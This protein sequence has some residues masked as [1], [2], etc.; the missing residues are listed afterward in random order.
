MCRMYTDF[1]SLIDEEEPELLVCK[2]VST[3]ICNA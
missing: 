3:D 2:A 1:T